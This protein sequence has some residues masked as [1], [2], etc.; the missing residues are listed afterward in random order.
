MEHGRYDMTLEDVPG[1]ILSIRQTGVPVGLTAT[2]TEPGFL[3]SDGTALLESEKDENGFY[4]GGAGMDGMY[5]K[6]GRL[7][8]PVRDEDGTVTGFRQMSR[9]LGAFTG[10]EQKIIYQYAMNTKENL[11]ADLD[12]VTQVVKQPQLRALFA[13]TRNKLAQVPDQECPRLM[14]DIRGAYKGRHL[15]ELR[16][17]QQNAQKSPKNAKRKRS[18]E[19]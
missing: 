19:R 16:E 15:Q 3:L 6:T 5:L 10:E 17:R 14:G 1:V 13:S 9:F 7:Y 2:H 11:L 4:V 8:E 18:V 12:Q